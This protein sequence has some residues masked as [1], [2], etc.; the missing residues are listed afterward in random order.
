MKNCEDWASDIS[1]HNFDK[2]I[3]MNLLQLIY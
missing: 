2:Q 1:F 3:D